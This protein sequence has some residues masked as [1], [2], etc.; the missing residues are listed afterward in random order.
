MERKFY[1]Q[2]AASGLRMP[3][4]TDLVL[5]EQPEGKAVLFDGNKLARVVESAARRFKTPLAL[6]HMDLEVEKEALLATMGIGAEAAP[7]FHFDQPP[8][9]EQIQFLPERMESSLTTR[10]KAQIEAVSEVARHPDLVP[11]AMCIGPFSLMTKLLSDPITPVCVAGSGISAEED[12]EVLRMERTLELAF[13]MVEWSIR[14]KIRAGARA[15]CI[16]EPAAN[17]VYLSPRQIDRGS[18]IF[19]RYVIRL[20]RKIRQAL[21]DA[22]VDLIFHCCGEL[23]PSM[24]KGFG[25]LDPAILS[26]GSSRNLWEDAALISPQTVL[27]GNLPS[28][29]FYS[30]ELTVEAV[31][32]EAINLESRMKATGHPFILGSE[33]D[34]LSVPGREKVIASKV[35]AFLNA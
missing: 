11:V 23:V 33:C 6:A 24:V 17:K 4:G 5:H 31:A 10:L 14:A 29:R 26:L 2:L 13:R 19:E 22:G 1:L 30:D 35:D 3:I 8:T 16:A 20:H 18:D 25:D 32:A 15:V 34:V 21:E 9:L 28:K 12:V 27:F 7:T